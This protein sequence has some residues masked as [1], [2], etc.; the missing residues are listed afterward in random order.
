MKYIF[1]VLVSGFV[2]VACGQSDGGGQTLSDKAVGL[3]EVFIPATEFVMGSD[4]VDDS[5]L[6]QRYGFEQPLFVN[7]HPPHRVAVASFFLDRFEVS[8]VDYKRFVVA[9]G[10]AEPMMW[11]QNGYNVYDD[12]LYT[13]SVERLRMI[14]SDYFQ[15]DR[16]TRMMDKQA[17]LQALFAIQ[18][19]RDVLPVSGVNWSD[20]KD[21]CHWAGG[22]LPYEREWELAA[23][24]PEGLEYPWGN[25]W[26]VGHANTGFGRD[27]EGPLAPRGEYAV[28]RSPYGVQDMAGNVSEWVADWYEA[29][30][31]G[32]AMDRHF[33]RLHRVIRGGGA[34][35]GHY[36]LSVF[37][38]GARR[39]HARP[40]MRSTD[41]GFR[42][43]RS[44]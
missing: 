8:S 17:L 36:A 3:D 41:V 21:Y 40:D 29:Y 15:F 16:N 12:R 42:C 22:R 38:R 23:R 11:V 19:E 10:R 18:K 28:D 24:G 37:Y 43:A 32:D 34:G 9:T 2:L 6:Q 30:P 7:E 27:E 35:L 14:A 5:S 13:A 25:D 20:A 31:G 33:G 44:G 26:V 4:R 39:A 1:L